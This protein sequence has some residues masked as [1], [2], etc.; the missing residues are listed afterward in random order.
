MSH[1]L[2][3]KLSSRLWPVLGSSEVDG[4]I[5]LKGVGNSSDLIE[6]KEMLLNGTQLWVIL[7]FQLC[8]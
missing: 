2:T 6:R 8:V 3:F 5:F 7:I 4:C 1:L